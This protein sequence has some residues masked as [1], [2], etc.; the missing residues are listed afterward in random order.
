MKRT[1]ENSAIRVFWDSDK[2]THAGFCIGELPSVFDLHRHP[3][4]DLAAAPAEQIIQVIDMCPSGALRYE[5]LGHLE[6]APPPAGPKAV[7]VKVS[8]NGPYIITGDCKLLAADGTELAAGAR[9]AL[10]RC[11][12]SRTMPHCD[13]TH[14]RIAFKKPPRQGK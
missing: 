8:D 7:T 11:G 9:F 14:R 12:Q 5:A 10:C 4:V 2:C 13:G 1:Y 6:P 3:W